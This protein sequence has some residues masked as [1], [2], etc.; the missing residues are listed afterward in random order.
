ALEFFAGEGLSWGRVPDRAITYALSGRTDD[1]RRELARLSQRPEDEYLPPIHFVKI[2]AALGD[3]DAAL[4]WADRVIEQRVNVGFIATEPSWRDSGKA[5]RLIQ[6]LEQIG[7]GPLL[8]S[9]R[10]IE[11]RL[12]GLPLARP[13]HLTRAV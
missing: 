1:A 7:M 3:Y 11:E 6:R 9:R 13:A 4:E 10:F 2:H 5:P 12:E 8:A